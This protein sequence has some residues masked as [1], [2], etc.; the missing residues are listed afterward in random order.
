[1]VG[2]ADADLIAGDTLIEIKTTK[3]GA[4]ERDQ[5]R[6]LVGYVCLARASQAYEVNKVAVYASRFA[7]LQ[8]LPL[9]P[10]I[11]N[12]AYLKAAEQL[13]LLWQRVQSSTS[14]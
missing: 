4:I 1:M 7:A 11:P 10:E 6:Q 13:A 12:A 9:K 5:V 8:E 2:G 3:T 14:E